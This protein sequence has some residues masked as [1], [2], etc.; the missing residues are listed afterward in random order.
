MC[1]HACSL[2]ESCARKSLVQHHHSQVQFFAVPFVITIY[3]KSNQEKLLGMRAPC[4]VF[5]VMTISI[6]FF[7][8]QFSIEV[9]KYYPIYMLNF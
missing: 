9:D 3:S 4:C 5:L 1:I 8:L 2:K 7:L 6:I